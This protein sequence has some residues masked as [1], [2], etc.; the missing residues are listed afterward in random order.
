MFTRC[1][2][3][4]DGSI[5]SAHGY[6]IQSMEP[7]EQAW[8]AACRAAAL[9]LAEAR[10]RREQA[11]LADDTA[12][13]HR[14]TPAPPSPPPPQPPPKGGPPRRG[15]QEAAAAELGIPPWSGGSVPM[16][17]GMAVFTPAP[18]PPPDD[19]EA[20]AQAAGPSPRL[21]GPPCGASISSSGG[22]A[23]EAPCRSPGA[24][25]IGGSPT[26]DGLSPASA[27]V[28]SLEYSKQQCL[29]IGEAAAGA[30]G[31][32]QCQLPPEEQGSLRESGLLRPAP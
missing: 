1:E 15:S 23:P 4:P 3:L 27:R 26:A 12:M 16:H 11:A 24:S 17:L 19:S 8:G 13:A 32:S 18:P 31:V 21:T 29:D 28:G 10:K 6:Y 5:A 20:D 7:L 22:G 2:G 30:P 9:R 25:G 14:S